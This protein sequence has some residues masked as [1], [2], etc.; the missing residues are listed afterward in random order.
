MALERSQKYA[1]PRFRFGYSYSGKLGMW[2]KKAYTDGYAT[3]LRLG[4]WSSM[5]YDYV[6]AGGVAV[7]LLIYLVYAL[8]RPEAR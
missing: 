2:P 5:F 4:V 3:V 8:V 1:Q 6:F 7:F